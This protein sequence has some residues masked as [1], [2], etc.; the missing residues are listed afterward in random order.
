M[1]EDH[2]QIIIVKFQYNQQSNNI[3]ITVINK[4][5]YFS[6]SFHISSHTL[7]EIFGTSRRSAILQ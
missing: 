2:I 4:K 6:V 5:V 1:Y 7:I 3:S